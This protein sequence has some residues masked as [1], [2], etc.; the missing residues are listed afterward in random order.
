VLEAGFGNGLESNSGRKPSGL[1]IDLRAEKNLVT[2][3]MTLILFGRVL[4]LLDSKYM[5]GMVFNSTGSTYYSRFPEAD[6]VALADP[7]RFYL[8]RRI[9]IGIAVGM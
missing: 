6:A 2:A 4:N 5:N 9:E 7:T 8:P 1:V 3:D